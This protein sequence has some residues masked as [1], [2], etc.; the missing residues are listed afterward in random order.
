[1]DKRS[2]KKKVMKDVFL[3]LIKFNLL[4]IPFYAIIILDLDFYP[5]QIAFTNFLAFI[6]SSLNYPVKTSEFFLFVGEGG[7][8]IDISRDCIG[9]KSMYSLFA[10]VF[11]TSGNKRI[12]LRFLL[13]WLP[14]LFVVNILRTLITILVGLNFGLY[15]LELVHTFLWQQVMIFTLV[16]IFYIWLRKGKLN[17]Q[18]FRNILYTEH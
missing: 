4:L 16:G 5:L 15:Y 18:S 3:F 14:V 17:I 8:P 1:M 2:Q 11:A 12:K 6:L 7:L 13:I 10:L 9:W